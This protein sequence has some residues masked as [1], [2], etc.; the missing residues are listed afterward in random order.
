MPVLL[1][2]Y[3]DTQLIYNKKTALKNFVKHLFTLEYKHLNHIQYVFCTDE[4]L[5]SVNQQF[6]QHNYYTDIITFDLSDTP[7]FIN[8]EVYISV[9]RIKENALVHKVTFEAE[10][11][12]VVFHGAL[13]LCGYA[14]KTQKQQLLMRTKEDFYI[15]LYLKDTT[16]SRGAK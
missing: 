4:Y 1:F 2:S 6:L 10:L 8:A 13:H 12:R 14:D 11:A 5:L 9:D 16:V 15:N 7:D 3:A